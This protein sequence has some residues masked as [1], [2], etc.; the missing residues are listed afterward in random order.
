MSFLNDYSGPDSEVC[1]KTK[2]IL[3]D[4]QYQEGEIFLSTGTQTPS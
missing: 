4:T 1:L 2:E 3:S